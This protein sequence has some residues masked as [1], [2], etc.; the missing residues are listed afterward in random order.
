MLDISAI[1]IDIIKMFL[2]CVIYIRESIIAWWDTGGYMLNPM[3]I[4][5]I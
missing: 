3:G 1:I 5:D 2:T 4:K